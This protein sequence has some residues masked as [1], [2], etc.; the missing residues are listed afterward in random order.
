MCIFTSNE[1]SQQLYCYSKCYTF[2]ML[3]LV[4]IS[5]ELVKQFSIKLDIL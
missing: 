3:L 1:S 2:V 4:D 5:A